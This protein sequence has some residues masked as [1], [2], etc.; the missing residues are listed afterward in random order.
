MCTVWVAS[1][2]VPLSVSGNVHGQNFRGTHEKSHM[3]SHMEVLS[4]A[5]NWWVS[6]QRGQLPTSKPPQRKAAHDNVPTV[7]VPKGTTSPAPAGIAG[8]FGSHGCPTW[9]CTKQSTVY[10]EKSWKY[11]LLAKRSSSLAD[12]HVS[13]VSTRGQHG[14]AYLCLLLLTLEEST[15]QSENKHQQRCVLY[16]RRFPSQ[17]PLLRLDNQDMLISWFTPL[18]S[19]KHWPFHDKLVASLVSNGGMTL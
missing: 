17:K 11:H 6:F 1:M 16:T 19:L 3:E 2:V 14:A 18:L 9:R 15:T 13:T 10:L 4:M 8:D 5:P 12:H 7:V